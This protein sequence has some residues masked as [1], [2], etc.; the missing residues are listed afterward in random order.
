MSVTTFLSQVEKLLKTGDATEHSY[1]L[2]LGQL[3][4][5]VLAPSQAIN[6]PKHK[7]YGA[8]DFIIQHDSSP[9]G[10]V[11]AKD[12][13]TDLAHAIADSGKATP[14]TSNGKQLQRYRAA[15][16]NLLYTDG[17]EW[18]WFVD[19]QPRLMLPICVGAW[20]KT[21]KQLKISTT[22]VSDL[23]TLL[24][25]FAAHN[26]LTVTTPLDLAQRLARIA[27]WL[28]EVINQIFATEKVTG[29]L[30][31]QLTAF[32]DTL[33]PNL[34]P[35]EFADMYAQTLVYGLF[36]ARVAHPKERLFS[37]LTAWNLIP[38]TNP[39]LRRMFHE[40]T[41][42]DLDPRIAWL[43]DD[44]ARLLGHTEMSAVMAHFGKATKQEDPVV[45][46]YET[47]LH[48]Y[49]PKL[50][51]TRGV[52]YTPEPVVSYLVRSVDSLLRTRFNRP[53]G[54]A[55]EQTIVL[56][57]ATGTGTFLHRVVQQIHANLADQGLAGLWDQYVQQN[58]LPRIF[59]FELLVA[60]YTVAHLKL[61]LLLGEL[62]YRFGGEERLG[63]YLT[64]TIADLPAQ[65][66]A[67][68]F[69]QVIAEEGR[70]ANRVK[71][72]EPVMVVI[73][74]PP[75]SGQSA[76]KGEWVEKLLKGEFEGRP[77][78]SY[79][80]VDG[81]PLGERNPKW[82]QDDYV[83]FIRFGQWRINRTGEGILAFI[84][85][86]GYLDNPTFR[87][88]RQSVLREFDK[89]YIL[90]LHGSSKKKERAPDGGPDENVFDIQQGVAI[91][92][93]IK[94]GRAATPATKDA[95]VS[96]ADLWGRR[97]DKYAALNALDV[98]TTQWQQLK[99]T[100]PFYLFV[101]QNVED[102]AEY[103]Q[104]WKITEAMLVQSVGIATARDRLTIHWS[105]QDISETIRRF[106]SLP[107]EEARAEFN[108]GPDARDWKVALAQA[109]LRDHSITG[110]KVAAIL[111]RPFDVRFTYY[112]GRSRGFLCM[113]RPDVMRHIQSG[114][115]IALVTSRM[116]KGETFHHAQVTTNI[117][118]VICMS[119]KTSNNG[120]V[121]P[122]YLDPPVGSV[123]HNQASLLDTNVGIGSRD[124]RPNLSPAFIS[125]LEQRLSMQFVPDGKGDLQATFGPEDIFHYAYALLHSPTYRSRYAEFLK[126]D[127]PRLP[128]TSNRELFAALAAKGA[129]LVDLH[130]LRLPGSGGV[131]GAGGATILISP[132]KQGVA[133]P[134]PGTNVVEKIQY[135]APL[136]ASHGYVSINATQRFLGVDPQ[137]WEMQIGGYQPLEKW[138]KDRKGR[139]LETGDVQ[140]YLRMIIALRETRRIMAEI[141]AII[142][143]WPLA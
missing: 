1:R 54:L 67:F 134:F 119:P 63:V 88:M 5:A 84:T 43:V 118:E 50:R 105:K 75:Y 113:P 132:G 111:Y 37:R 14:S 74:N 73:G 10:H 12:V 15:L 130:L 115:N 8:P 106:S 46:F 102:Q 40:V 3:F 25:Q 19:G 55:D 59:G 16:P 41:A 83:K 99:P 18:H 58:L 128:L 142:P 124:R 78:T 28:D 95:V 39:F 137:T 24:Q 127:F 35:A 93:F 101:P 9:I 61:G 31:R 68:A 66:A 86:N 36:A 42:E 122:L 133:Y 4:D 17:L 131:G 123:Q 107:P 90:N 117:V 121:F 112:T 116:T 103:D 141:D 34:G 120:F 44:C 85:N 143:A 60:P 56:D 80:E 7:K 82:L 129:E 27:R 76:N 64:N 87:G 72:S 79:Y 109:D 51:E 135:E 69:A 13:G 26:A 30:H 33:L 94:G 38:K 98:D 108:L 48:A 71:Q 100:S 29:S 20:N 62:G 32:R 23:T 47:F 91:A 140:H 110:G 70:Q 52:Y 45:H 114:E 57:P 138:L 77:V 126:I 97:E 53:L 21:S 89:I 49:D 81:K 125:D 2:A 92:L 11:E 139:K 65:Q 22:A 136:D 104:G 6:E 96:Y